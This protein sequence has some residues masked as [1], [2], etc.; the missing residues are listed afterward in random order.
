[1]KEEP[2]GFM[3][4]E[5][6]KDASFVPISEELII[7]HKFLEPPVEKV[8]KAVGVSAPTYVKAK[9]VVEAAEQDPAKAPL[10]E[11]MDRTG[12]DDEVGQ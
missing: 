5:C 12:K 8:A 2:P 6:Q 9:A 10:V 1:M 11:E 4:G 7:T 3:R